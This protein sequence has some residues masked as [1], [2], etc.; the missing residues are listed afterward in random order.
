MKAMLC[1]HSGQNLAGFFELF[2]TQ[3]DARRNAMA[4]QEL[5]LLL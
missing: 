5:D 3:Q 2:L 1:G 4:H